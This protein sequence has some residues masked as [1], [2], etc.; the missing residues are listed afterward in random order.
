MATVSA[1]SMSP[2]LSVQSLRAHRPRYLKRGH[3]EIQKGLKGAST[4]NGAANP[5]LDT[6]GKIA[7]ALGVRPGELLEE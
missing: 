3:P 2:S 5:E 4:E 7:N 1:L 6:L